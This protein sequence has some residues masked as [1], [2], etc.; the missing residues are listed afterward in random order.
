MVRLGWIYNNWLW[1]YC[2]WQFSLKKLF[3]G[4]FKMWVSIEVWNLW[5]K[6]CT[7]II[8]KWK[9]FS[10]SYKKCRSWPNWVTNLQF[11]FLKITKFVVMIEGFFFFFWYFKWPKQ[12]KPKTAASG[13]AIC[14]CRSYI[15][16]WIWPWC[17]VE[18][19]ISEEILIDN[20]FVQGSIHRV[21]CGAWGDYNC[22][23]S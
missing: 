9:I 1:W 7:W 14:P 17:L 13:R 19:R 15:S 8:N 6:K 23:L 16:P 20:D 12:D 3:Y 2:L 21:L 11:F 18:S 4:I 5:K 22:K 10:T